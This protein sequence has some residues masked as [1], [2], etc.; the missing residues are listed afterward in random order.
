MRCVTSHSPLTAQ[1]EEILPSVQAILAAAVYDESGATGNASK[2]ALITHVKSASASNS[3]HHS[4]LVPL[5]AHAALTFIAFL[6]WTQGLSSEVVS[7]SARRFTAPRCLLLGLPPRSPLRWAGNLDASAFGH[8]DGHGRCWCGVSRR[9]IPFRSDFR[10]A[11][12]SPRPSRARGA[13]SCRGSHRCCCVFYPQ[14]RR[15]ALAC[16]AGVLS[17][18]RQS[19]RSVRSMVPSS[20]SRL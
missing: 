6:P 8:S 14:F 9:R 10:R 12:H 4:Y 3:D 18:Y 17:R 1:R 13:R 15:S 2:M 5:V 11:G 16:C 19:A 7:T 20:N